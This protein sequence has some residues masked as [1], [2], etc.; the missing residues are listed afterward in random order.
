MQCVSCFEL[1]LSSL[2]QVQALLEQSPS[3]PKIG[4][5][6]HLNPSQLLQG[7]RLFRSRI[8]AYQFAMPQQIQTLSQQ[9]VGVLETS[10]EATEAPL[11]DQ[12][13][14]PSPL[15]VRRQPIQSP[16]KEMLALLVAHL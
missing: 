6:V 2:I 14:R 9:S 12:N 10:R 1:V 3:L 11:P 16:L 7:E 8:D 4:L 15:A 5:G 13:S